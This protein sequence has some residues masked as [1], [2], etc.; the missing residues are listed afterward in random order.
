M[1]RAGRHQ[2]EKNSGA[3]SSPGRTGTG[4]LLWP[5]HTWASPSLGRCWPLHYCQSLLQQRTLRLP[6]PRTA[7]WRAWE[8]SCKPDCNF[9]DGFCVSPS[10]RTSRLEQCKQPQGTFQS[11]KLEK[12]YSQLRRSATLRQ[13]GEPGPRKSIV[14]PGEIYLARLSQ[15][16][17]ERDGCLNVFQQTFG[18]LNSLK[19]APSQLRLLKTEGHRSRLFLPLALCYSTS[20]VRHVATLKV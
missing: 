15:N 5:R 3:A 9:E 18:G 6:Q 19:D 20:T 2:Q 10:C 11:A 17:W 1:L 8:P 4:R 14:V 7:C 13:R 12:V 16:Q